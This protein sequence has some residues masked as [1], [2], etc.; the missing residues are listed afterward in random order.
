MEYH[1]PHAHGISQYLLTW[2]IKDMG[3]SRNPTS[4]FFLKKPN[5]Q[6][7]KSR[8]PTSRAVV[9]GI[10]QGAMSNVKG[11]ANGFLL[12]CACNVIIIML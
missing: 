2:N 10:G 9:V 4:T 1:T 12:S 11:F 7:P 5:A 3:S 6:V 8:N